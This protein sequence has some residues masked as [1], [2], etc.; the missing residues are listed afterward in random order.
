MIIDDFGYPPIDRAG[1]ERVSRA[2]PDR[3][4]RAAE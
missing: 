1:A 4:P 2:Y 3:A